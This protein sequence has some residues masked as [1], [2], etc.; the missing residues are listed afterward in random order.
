MA[1]KKNETKKVQDNAEMQQSIL[2]SA[3]SKILILTDEVKQAIDVLIQGVEIG[4]KAGVYSLQ[5]AEFISKAVRTLGPHC[6]DEQQE[7]NLF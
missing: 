2:N 6:K 5:D 7:N 3:K 4:Q 1:E